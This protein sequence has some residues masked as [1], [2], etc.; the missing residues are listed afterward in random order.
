MCDSIQSLFC[1]PDNY[2]HD[3]DDILSPLMLIRSLFKV[4][5]DVNK[6]VAIVALYN[7]MLCKF[8]ICILGECDII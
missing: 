7:G 6:G 5:W 2:S 4:A 3:Y 8:K 1:Q